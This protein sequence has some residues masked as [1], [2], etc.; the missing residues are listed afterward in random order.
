MTCFFKA[1]NIKIMRIKDDEKRRALVEATVK[2]VNMVGFA[3]SSVAKIAAEAGV[4]PSTLYIYFENKE[5][6]LV[7]T[8]NDI[9]CEI[10]EYMLQRIS[11]FEPTREC[12]RQICLNL[13]DYMLEHYDRAD[14]LEQFG[15]SPYLEL[16]DMVDKDPGM[17]KFYEM[18]EA[19]VK[20][21]MVKDVPYE[22]VV[23]FMFKPIVTLAIEEKRCYKRRLQKKDLE[24]VF[25][26]AW[27]AISVHKQD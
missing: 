7:S 2:L 16:I 1:G 5:D 13:F 20:L 21:G 9:K 18:L 22:Y 14:F 27:D 6:L 23:R 11:P 3:A 17:L 19:A 8:Y 26:M 4:S 25:N 15:T 10:G 12:F 24:V